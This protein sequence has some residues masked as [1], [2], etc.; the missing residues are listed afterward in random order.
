MLSLLKK[1]QIGTLADGSK[2]FDYGSKFFA[3]SN[4]NELLKKT[5]DIKSDEPFKHYDIVDCERYEYLEDVMYTNEESYTISA[6]LDMNNVFVKGHE[7]DLIEN[8]I[9]NKKFIFCSSVDY[10][11]FDEDDEEYS[12]LLSACK[13]IFDDDTIEDIS[14]LDN[15]EDVYISFVIFENT[16]AVLFSQDENE[17]IDIY[18]MND[19]DEIDSLNI[20]LTISA[21]KAVERIAFDKCSL[22]N[23]D[24]IEKREIFENIKFINNLNLNDMKLINISKVLSMNYKSLSASKDKEKYFNL[25]KQELISKLLRE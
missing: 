18:S 3:I 25:Y 17:D 12:I 4:K 7:I 22:I 5:I 16:L 20:E 14:V 6:V 1:Q 15:D 8:T 11:D 19:N 10:I 9:D 13:I 2:V 21:L 23:L 24:E